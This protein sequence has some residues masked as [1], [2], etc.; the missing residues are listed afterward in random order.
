MKR[1]GGEHFV[2]RIV[3]QSENVV[4]MRKTCYGIYNV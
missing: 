2:W 3:F 4:D 1:W